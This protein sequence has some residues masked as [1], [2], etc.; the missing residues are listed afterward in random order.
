MTTM[1]SPTTKS[2]TPTTARAHNFSAG[3]AALPEAVLRRA[4][5]DLWDI[6]GSG[7]GICEHSH[8]APVFDKVI[9]EAEADCRKLGNIPDNY[10]VL[11]LQG[12]ATLQ[13]G[14]IPMNLLRKDQTADYLNT[15]EWST[16][17]IK[18]AKNFGNVNVVC[19]SEDKNFAYIPAESVRKYTP[20]A[21]YCHYTSNNTIFGTQ[22]DAVPSATAGVPLVC[23]ASSD[24][25]SRPIDIAKH[26]L[27]YAGAQKNLGPSGCALVIVR[28]D[29]LERGPKDIP[30][31]LQYRVHA[32]DGSRHNTPNTFAIYL[33][34][35]VFKW[36]LDQGGLPAFAKLNQAKAD[37][38]YGYLDS[39]KVFYATAEKGSRSRMNI[40]FR[41]RGEGAVG[42]EREK[43]FLAAADVANLLNLKGHRSVGGMRAS[44]Y[45]AV[46]IESVKAL[47]GAMEKFE[48]TA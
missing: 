38:L 33:M 34:G 11:F 16:R 7:I 8:R 13:F 1:T 25:F 24:I 47:I 35:Q 31:M 41:C 17:A 4:Q 27:I 19:S 18:E 5:A 14:M 20:G 28:D 3:P 29:L 43:K 10:K 46:P 26:A 45:N 12:G 21:A 30:L 37:L 40:C 36:M 32:K 42:E 44:V 15:G 39:S 2:S 23:D 6:A 9:A 22:F 48:K